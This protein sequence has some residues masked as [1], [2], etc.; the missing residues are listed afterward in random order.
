MG[1]HLEPWRHMLICDMLHRKRFTTSQIA[2]AAECSQCSIR[3]IHS[4]LIM[5]GTESPPV[6]PGG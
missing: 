1:R 4:H 6:N 3:N 5:F 2:D